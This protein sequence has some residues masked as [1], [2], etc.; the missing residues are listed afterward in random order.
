MPR[1]TLIILSAFVV[2]SCASTPHYDP[3]ADENLTV[4][5]VQREIR[6]AASLQH[7]H[8]VPLLTAGVTPGDLL[9]YVMP[10]IE[11]ESLR[12]RLSRDGEL[13]IEET[14]R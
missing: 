6:L 1:L 8:I 13:P 9:Y 5:T 10:Y 7:P 4:G 2:L 3:Q 11:G 14:T 12:T